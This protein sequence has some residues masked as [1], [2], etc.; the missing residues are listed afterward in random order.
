VIYENKEFVSP[1]V[2]RS[3]KRKAEG[4]KYA[5]RKVAERDREMRG[6]EGWKSRKVQELSEANLFA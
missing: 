3:L 6:R 1:N 4:S 5:G 2:A